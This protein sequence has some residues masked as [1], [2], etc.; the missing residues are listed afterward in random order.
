MARRTADDTVKLHARLLDAF[1][2]LQENATGPLTGGY[3]AAAKVAECDARTA[4]RG[5]VKGWP[6]YGLDSIADIVAAEQAAARAA[7]QGELSEAAEASVAVVAKEKA[8]ARADA[9]KARAEEGKLV[10]AAR[11]NIVELLEN[12]RELLAGYRKLAPRVSKLIAAI[13]KKIDKLL[14][15]ESET[16]DIGE[17]LDL[18]ERTAA[19]LWRL[20]TSARASTSAGMQALQMERLL[21]GQPTEIIGVTDLD[22]MDED[23]AIAELEAAADVAKRMR[24]RKKRREL[25]LAASNG[26]T[27]PEKAAGA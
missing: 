26:K 27:I 20:S 22:A 18:V 7:I 5:F 6:D 2:V 21:L 4:K 11:G 15:E 16:T 25:R 17:M 3:A 12:G 24:A 13:E 19:V 23:E 10:R 14:A 9:I 1:R 8:A